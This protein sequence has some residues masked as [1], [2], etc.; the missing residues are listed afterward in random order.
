MVKTDIIEIFELM[1]VKKN[2]EAAEKFLKIVKT[3]KNLSEFL[4]FTRQNVKDN[5]QNIDFV[6]V[7]FL[8][9]FFDNQKLNKE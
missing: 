2:K 8:I 1:K 6:L 9:D 4:S 3:Q 7:N 5:Y